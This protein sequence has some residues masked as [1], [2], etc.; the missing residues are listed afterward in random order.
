MRVVADAAAMTLARCWQRRREG[1][2]GT[3]DRERHSPNPNPNPNPVTLT[4]MVLGCFLV[5]SHTKAADEAV[6]LPVLA[7]ADASLPPPCTRSVAAP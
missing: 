2:R 6:R 3:Y 7:K 1:V 4:L 5:D